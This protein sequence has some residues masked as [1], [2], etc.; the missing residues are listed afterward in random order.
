MRGGRLVTLTARVK[1]LLESLDAAVF[2]FYPQSWARLPAVSWR[3]SG[4]R[5]IARADGLP[6]LA[7]VTYAVDVFSPSAAQ[8]EAL[9][10]EIDRRMTGARLRRDYMADLF[11][12]KTGCHHRSLRYR[13]VADAQGRVY[14]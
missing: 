7:E 3:E 5:E 10:E 11:D 13:C 14:Q 4:N 9:A 8:N 2:Y 12:A 1:A 6:H